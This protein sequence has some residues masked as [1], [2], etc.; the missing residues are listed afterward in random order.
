MKNI[1]I[2][3]MTGLLAGCVMNELYTPPPS[4]TPN[5]PSS[6]PADSSN[7]HSDLPLT[8]IKMLLVTEG[9][10]L[11]IDHFF[12]DVFV[13]GVQVSELVN[14]VY[15]TKKSKYYVSQ[16]NHS[17]A[18]SL[19]GENMAF[20]ENIFF[21]YHSEDET[22]LKGQRFTQYIAVPNVVEINT[23]KGDGSESSE[24]AIYFATEDF[25]TQQD[26]FMELINFSPKIEQE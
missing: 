16:A 11:P 10:V 9:S 1:F 17:T 26:W 6:T 12:E 3:I 2:I 24:N 15:S 13:N 20:T 19:E 14:N 25:L 23:R 22:Y 21:L 18:V 7:L 8:F 5:V 4:S